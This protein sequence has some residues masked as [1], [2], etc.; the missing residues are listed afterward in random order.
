MMGTNGETGR[1]D[2]ISKTLCMK[3]MEKNVLNAKMLEM[4]LLGTL[5]RL[6]RDA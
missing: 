2:K 1:G 3:Y 5:L 6:E 4:S